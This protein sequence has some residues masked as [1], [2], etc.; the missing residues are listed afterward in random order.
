[1]DKKKIK[2]I[3]FKNSKKVTEGSYT[4]SNSEIKNM[5][6]KWMKKFNKKELL[7]QCK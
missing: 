5:G 6:R 2:Y 7:K 3:I 1:M 4:K